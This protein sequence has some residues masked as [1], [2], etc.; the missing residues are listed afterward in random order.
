MNKKIKNFFSRGI[1]LA[2]LAAGSQELV[3]GRY[4]PSRL[5]QESTSGSSGQPFAVAMD[6]GYRARRNL[7]FLR[8]LFDI[9]YRP[10]Q[11]LMLITSRKQGR[12]RATRWFYESLTQTP[13]ELLHAHQTIKPDIVYGSVTPLRLL[14]EEAQR[15]GQPLH[16]PKVVVST[17]E[18]LVAT[19]RDQLE[20][21]FCAPVA[22][23]YGST[24]MGL[25]AWQ[26]PEEPFYRFFS[27]SVV[28]ELLPFA[29]TT[30]WFELLLTN[31]ELRSAPIIRLLSSDLARVEFFDGIPRIVQFQGRSVDV[32]WRGDEPVSPYQLTMELESMVG[33]RRFQ[34]TQ[35]APQQFTATVECDAG[36]ESTVALQIESLVQRQ[37]GDAATV[38]TSV[39]EHIPVEG[40][41]KHQPIR[42]LMTR[43]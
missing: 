15:V 19:A 11:K 42:C 14:I 34:F 13:A 22:D 37:F 8:A 18:A 36:Y 1:L 27:N 17:S 9:G 29:N 24:E 32:L 39:V 31:L 41:R 16:R 30:G 35:H 25:V 2:I 28:V 3:D 23:F 6:R 33:M 43:H 40:R 10:G 12:V 21:G 26:R 38:A 5:A 7:R 4:E 20:K